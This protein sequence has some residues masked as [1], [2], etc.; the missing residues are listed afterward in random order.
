MKTLSQM[1]NEAFKLFNEL[2]MG[3]FFDTY[4]DTLFYL[5]Q[6]IN[7]LENDNDDDYKI[8]LELLAQCKAII[9]AHKILINNNIY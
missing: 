5:V 6:Q 8:G 9:K 2:Q 1:Q 3:N 7:Y 4:H